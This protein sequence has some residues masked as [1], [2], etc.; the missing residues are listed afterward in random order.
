MK[1]A[2]FAVLLFS[3]LARVAAL[4]AQDP[5]VPGPHRPIFVETVFSSGTLA[6]FSLGLLYDQATTEVPRW[7]SGT[8]GFQ[9]RAEWRMGGLLSRPAAEY[10]VTKWRGTDPGYQRCQCKGFLP[11]S[12]YAVVSEFV[13]RRTEG[14]LAAPVARVTGIATGVLV[15]S[16]GQHSGVGDAW[17]RGI[18]LAGN[19]IGFNVLQEF[20]PEIKRTLLLRRK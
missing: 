14:G 20:W 4:R 19:D 13:E 2:R 17:K 3:G 11:R 7:G 15:T 10:G 6:K 18:V 8:A 16:L 12:R 9:K 5:E 1:A